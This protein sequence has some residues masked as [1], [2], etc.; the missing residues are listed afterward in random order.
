MRTFVLF[1]ACWPFVVL[2]D[3]ETGAADTIQSLR[4]ELERMKA[5]QAAR[6]AEM[7]RLEE[8]IAAF[9]AS[10]A[11]PAA[12]PSSPPQPVVAAQSAEPPS[13]FEASGDFR[14]RYEHNAGDVSGSWDRGALRGRLGADRKSVV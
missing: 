4:A 13:R 11:Q 7:Q 1:L 8:R 6:A 14:L 3:A 12:T 2:A 5:E 10:A 9:E